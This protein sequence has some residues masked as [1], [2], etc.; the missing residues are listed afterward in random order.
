MRTWSRR[1]QRGYALSEAMV[2]GMLLMFAVSGVTAGFVQARSHVVRA[3]ADRSA[4]QYG[5]TQIERLR[6]LKWDAPHWLTDGNDKA[7]LWDASDPN[8]ST[9]TTPKLPQGWTCFIDV[10]TVT[11]AEVLDPSGKRITGPR[12]YKVARVKLT[13]REL[14]WTMETLR[15]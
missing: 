1:R 6:A 12:Q 9:G 8:V 5:I 10:R 15:W 2:G 7:C 13:Y 11:E 14:K 3:M 4:A